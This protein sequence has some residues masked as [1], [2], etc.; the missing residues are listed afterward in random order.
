[1][2]RTKLIKRAE[3]G[4]RGCVQVY[5]A[6]QAVVREVGDWK[7]GFHPNILAAARALN[8]TSKKMLF[9]AER[10]GMSTTTA[11]KFWGKINDANDEIQYSLIN[12]TQPGPAEESTNINE[13]VANLENALGAWGPE[14]SA[15]PVGFP[16]A[17]PAK[18]KRPPAPP[19]WVPPVGPIAVVTPPG[20]GKSGREIKGPV[21]TEPSGI[22]E[23]TEARPLR[24]Y[25]HP[26]VPRLNPYNPNE[27]LPYF[28]LS[29]HGVLPHQEYTI[30]PQGL[31]SNSPVYGPTW[32]LNQRLPKPLPETAPALTPAER[33]FYFG[34]PKWTEKGTTGYM[35]QP[36]LNWRMI[37]EGKAPSEKIQKIAKRY[38]RLKSL[39][40]KP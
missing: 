21:P 4:Y 29:P 27:K 13:A 35:G 19:P 11:N 20:G 16:A 28:D 14:N 7:E 5:R 1:M 22:P 33:K 37:N 30:N 26:T 36:E 10:Y 25:T 40:E 23:F 3:N 6:A 15:P 34:G 24:Q 38:R 9:N 12:D 32:E 17:N 31:P 39:A 8:S 18:P 2:E